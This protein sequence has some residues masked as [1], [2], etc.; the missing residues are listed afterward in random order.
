ME[1]FS[2][3]NADM[4]EQHE[5]M[6]NA[7]KLNALGYNVGERMGSKAKEQKTFGEARTSINH[8][9]A[10]EVP[11]ERGTFAEVERALKTEKPKVKF[12]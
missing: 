3:I 12:K 6:E 2:E 5:A 4:T 7:L 10:D 1:R 11:R 9:C 8:G